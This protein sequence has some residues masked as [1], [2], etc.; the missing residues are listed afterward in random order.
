MA[1]LSAVVRAPLLLTAGLAACSGG[2]SDYPIS[3]PG[4]S[5]DAA[6][7]VGLAPDG[8]LPDASPGAPDATTDATPPDARPTG[9]DLSIAI[10]DSSDPV[11]ASSALTYK[12]VVTNGGLL[13]AANVVVTQRLPPGDI[14]FLT[15]AGIDWSCTA[16][17]QVVTCTRATLL[18]GAAPS[19]A[20]KV[21]TPPIGGSITTSAR[22]TSGSADPDPS[23]DDTSATTLV[24]TPADL[25]IAITGAPDPVAAGGTLTYTITVT[26][27]GP[28]I[29]TGITVLDSLPSGVAIASASGSGWSCAVVGQNVTC[30]SPT[31]AA[32]AASVITVVATAPTSGGAVS[33][34]A[35]VAAVTPDG[36]P[37]NNSASTSA[38]VNAAA[39]LAIA[40]SAS[41][42]SVPAASQLTYT[43]DVTNGGPRD[44]S[45]VVVTSRL[46][47]G[48]V[49]FLSA[50]G[51]GWG[52]TV[53]SQVVT[54]TRASLLA[55]EAPLI[56]VQI[57]TPAAS[58]TLTCDVTVSASTTDLD[59]SNNTAS[60]TTGVF[61]SADLSIVA[62]ESPDPVRIGT[63]LIYT[64]SVANDGPTAATAIKVVD[65]LP[66]GTAF[67]DAIAAPWSC[68]SLGRVVT[69]TLANLPS[70]SSAPAIA[71]VA[72]APGTA[73]NLT[74][75]ARVSSPTSDP[76]G[77]NNA[78][79]TV[80]L[81]N[82]FADLSVAISDDRDPIQGT[83]GSS[84]DN[85]ACVTY[86]I[87]V[88]N[89]GPDPAAGIRVVT[90][91]PPDGSFF[92]AVG[93]GW[94]CPAPGTTLTCTRV[95]L[96]PGPAPPITL[97]WKAPS[98]GGFSI[99]VNSAVSAASTDPAPDD[100]TATQDT[101]VKP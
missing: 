38:S 9:A 16:A 83:G 66:E 18:V 34:T 54:C 91:L 60:A 84:C 10:T 39:D 76:D 79:T 11:A 43:I 97:I 46:P 63:E 93:T 82:A 25:A 17:G 40:L 32:A 44:A 101:F 71:I 41:P 89:A 52:C 15:A 68:G 70:A 8:A 3:L 85:N 31:L 47:D 73:G 2:G 65:T 27:A 94:I 64:L 19:I 5:A 21:T 92:E 98:P 37:A 28:G 57:R 81:A 23:N 50:T 53:A 22:V 42:G 95:S 100:N 30:F 29:A 48:D 87:A 56:T 59:L 72:A 78:A 86:T 55:G 1:R 20:V 7:D 4:G 6:V 77:S 45:N 33:S 62:G 69:C 35:S 51:I 88:A 99:V 12:I 90:Q 67:V 36:N 49:L 13:D 96:D 61:D 80:T 74:N 24:L 26:N 14:Q 58:G 75:T